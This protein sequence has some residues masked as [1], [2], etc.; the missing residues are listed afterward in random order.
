MANIGWRTL[1]LLSLLQTHRFWPGSELAAELGVSRRTLRRDVERIREMGYEVTAH[2][3]VAGGYQLRAG[4]RLPTLLVLDDDEAV[5]V[6][7][8]LL[9]AAN[10]TVPGAEATA[11]RALAKLVPVM[12]PRVR[13]RAGALSSAGDT[14]VDV[15]TLATTALACRNG[16]RLRFD[17]VAGSGEHSSRLVEPLRLLSL[18]HRWYLLAWDVQRDAWRQFRLDRMTEPALTGQPATPREVPGE[19]VHAFVRTLTEH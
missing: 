6:V 17:Y 18:D 1:R 7:A 13:D 5:A 19:D 11:L 12:P 2:P 4:D 10:G 14:P 3:G 16:E 9:A 15:G 8:G